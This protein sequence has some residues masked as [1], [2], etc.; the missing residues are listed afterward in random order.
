MLEFSHCEL[1]LHKSWVTSTSVLLL[2]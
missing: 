2:A 1:N